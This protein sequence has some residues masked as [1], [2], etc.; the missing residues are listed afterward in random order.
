[1]TS[2]LKYSKAVCSKA[3]KTITHDFALTVFLSMVMVSL[4][5]Q[6]NPSKKDTSIIGIS[7][8]T[9]PLMQLARPAFASKYPEAH[10]KTIVD[11]TGVV[12]DSVITGYAAVAITTRT[13]KDYEKEKSGSL[14]GT[15]IGLD[16]LVLTVAK[17]NPVNSLTF[18][19]IVL[20]YTGAITN[21]KEVGGKNMAIVVIGRNKGFD[22]INLFADFMRLDTKFIKDGVQYS[23]KG[24][25]SWSKIPSLIPSTNEAAL[26]MLN[27]S[28]NAI[29]YFP[30]QV[31]NEY[32][33]Q[34]RN[35][36]PLAF[37]GI[38]ATHQTIENSSYFIHRQ[39]NAITKGIPG[40]TAQLLIDFLLSASGQ[41]LI[42][43]AGFLSLNN[44]K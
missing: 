43:K 35:L 3:K 8:T 11:Q 21:W 17:S 44:S 16:G 2:I 23:V 30:L 1:M 37:N 38:E 29:T 20:I 41:Q 24:E 19:Q 31:F 26:A 15:P 18:D 4:N 13:I 28:G 27:K 39:L 36:K 9:L 6:T 5:A 10:F 7:V 25:D 22:P 42:N 32:K 40:S 14:K 33:A 34:G 12:V